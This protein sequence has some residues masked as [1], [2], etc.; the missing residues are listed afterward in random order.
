MTRTIRHSF[1]IAVVAFFVAPFL[2][3]QEEFVIEPRFYK[4]G[5]F[6]EGL[7]AVSEFS[8]DMGYID[9]SGNWVIEPKFGEARGFSEGLAAVQDSETYKWGYIDNTGKYAIKP[10]Y[11]SAAD[12]SEGLAFVESYDYSGPPTYTY[13]DKTGKT[14]LS[15]LKNGK[16]TI[17]WGGSFKN[18]YAPIN[19]GGKPSMYGGTSG[20]VYYF[21]NKKGL[22]PF[23]LTKP[24]SKVGEFSEGL[25]IVQDGELLG[26]MDVNGKE[27]IKPK[28]AVFYPFSEGVAVVMYEYEKDTF[29]LRVID[30]K[31]KTLLEMPDVYSTGY[32]FSEGL[33]AVTLDNEQWGF[34]NLK[35]ELVIE[36]RFKGVS[37]FSGGYAAVLVEVDEGYRMIEKWGY[38]K[39]P[40][41]K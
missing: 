1:L 17:S 36:P 41:R 18:G 5:N 19:A 9:I 30:K 27:V 26:A 15:F 4:A 29:S 32:E 25:A 40:L 16:S 34:M 37:D 31:D 28:Y 35:R 23:K 38:I 8:G 20:G 22:V 24:Y 2:F 7:A 33:L 14:V 12:F 6:S 10:I 11:E 21:I 39:N 13:I 3:A